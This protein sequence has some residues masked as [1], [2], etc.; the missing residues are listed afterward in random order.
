MKHSRLVDAITQLQVQGLYSQV[1]S[2]PSPALYHPQSTNTFMTI[3]TEYPAV[4][5]PHL[6]SQNVEH[7]ITHHIRTT[8]PPISAHTRRLTPEKLTVARQEFQH[9]Q[10]QGIVCP[11]SSQWSS[12]LHMVP[13]KV[14][15]D[16][17]PCGDYRALNQITILD[18]YPIPH[19]QDFTTTLYGASIFSKLDLVRAYHQIPV[20]PDDV[21][22][23]AITTPFGLFEFLRMPLGLKNAAQTF[24]RFIDQVLRGLHFSY[25]YIDDV[26]I[27]SS[28]PEE[29]AQHLRA[30]L[31]RFQQY[32]VIINPAKCELGVETLQ[33]LGHQVDSKGIQP[34]KTK[35]QVIQEFP[36][37]D[38]RKKLRQF[39]GLVNFYH[40]FVKNCI[41]IIKPLND[42]STTVKDDV[43]K[44][45]WND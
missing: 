33:F 35:V 27:A 15:G 34:L 45:Q 21:P 38:T 37:P 25:A 31:E 3:V 44:L 16:W 43:R 30:V 26:L 10:E 36:C 32:G 24:Q 12:P 13:K 7:D 2:S 18:C 14:P 20:E 8:G 22:K 28:S 39:L 4:F 9:M 29:H 41:R 17:R 23:T 19:I 5:Q 40:R 42:L 11:S 6:H 1:S